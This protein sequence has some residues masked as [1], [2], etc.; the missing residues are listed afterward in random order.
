MSILIFA[1]TLLSNWSL[2]H[3]FRSHPDSF[4]RSH[5]AGNPSYSFSHGKGWCI[6]LLQSIC[7]SPLSFILPNDHK[8]SFIR[9]LLFGVRYFFSVVSFD[10]SAVSLAAAF[11]ESFVVSFAV[12]FTASI[13]V[14]ASGFSSSSLIVLS[15]VNFSST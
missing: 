4:S 15:K 9:V 7:T 2:Q 8:K 3:L 14:S 13:A 12:S 10:L 1:L 5:P 6:R 11:A